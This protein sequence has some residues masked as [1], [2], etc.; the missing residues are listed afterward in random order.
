MTGPTRNILKRILQVLVIAVIFYFIGRQIYEHWAEVVEYPWQLNF[1]YIA[2]ALILVLITFFIFSSV[3][4]LIIKTLGKPVGLC[5]AYKIAYLANLGRY[6]PG[7]VWQVFGM[8]YLAKKEGISEEESVTSFVLTQIFAIP[9][10]FF[11]GLLFLALDGDALD[12]FSESNYFSAGIIAVAMIIFMGSLVIVFFPGLVERLLNRLL[13]IMKR[14]PL[15]IV[16]N[17]SLAASIYAGYSLAWCLYGIAFWLFLKGITDQPA[18]VLS[19]TGIF[20]IAYQIGYLVLLAPGGV[21][22]REGALTLLLTPFFGPAALVVPIAARLWL[23]VAETLSA[24][25]ALKIK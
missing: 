4:R 23:I 1:W 7:K 22:P 16:I 18:A 3:W 25:V 9:A 17:K 2:L 20:I 5:K 15:R 8:I 10:A 12:K 6:I 14:P 11:T 19:M 24:L 21:G 13:K